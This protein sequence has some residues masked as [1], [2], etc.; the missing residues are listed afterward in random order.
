MVL[1][2]ASPN[3]KV[4]INRR[5]NNHPGRVANSENGARMNFP[6]QRDRLA[7]F[8]GFLTL[9]KKYSPLEIEGS[10]AKLTRTALK[11]TKEAIMR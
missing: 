7:I 2:K 10:L 6:A 5:V 9:S 4:T 8:P 1:K 11:N 3:L